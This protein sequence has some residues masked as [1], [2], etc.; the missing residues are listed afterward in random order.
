MEISKEQFTGLQEIDS[1]LESIFTSGENSI[2]LV[3]A[4]KKLYNIL[5]E[6]YAKEQFKDIKTNSEDKKE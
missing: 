4:R 1:I 6:I 3:T 5:V 2:L